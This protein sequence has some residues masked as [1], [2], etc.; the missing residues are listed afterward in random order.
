V[1]GH[2]SPRCNRILKDWVV[3]SAQ[4][5]HLYGVPEHKDRITRWNA[6]GRSGLYAGARHYLRLLRSLVKNQVPYLAP[7]GRTCGAAPEEFDAAAQDTWK[8]MQ[9]KWRTIP[10]GLDLM[11]DEAHPLGF[12]RRVIKETHDIQLPIRP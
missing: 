4:K 3:Q 10:G 6:E 5:I 9:N 1:Q 2:V 11:S 12:W 8:V 7:A